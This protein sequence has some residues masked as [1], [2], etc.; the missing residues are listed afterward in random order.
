VYSPSVRVSEGRDRK[1]TP[2]FA[3]DDQIGG[4]VNLDPS[5]AQSGRLT[6]SVSG[7]IFVCVLSL[8]SPLW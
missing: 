5:C 7:P 1:T 8:V 6:V 2:L 3:D 4:M